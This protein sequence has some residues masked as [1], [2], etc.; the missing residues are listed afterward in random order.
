MNLALLPSI[1]I[2]LF[3][4]TSSENCEL[5][6][7]RPRFPEYEDIYEGDFDLIINPE[8]KDK[9]LIL[10]WQFLTKHNADFFIFRQR[11]EK[12]RIEIIDPSNDKKITLELWQALQ[13][14]KA[15]KFSSLIQWKNIRLFLE[16]H[17]NT[18]TGFRLR[19]DIEICYYF[20]HLQ[21]K[22]KLVSAPLVK[23]RFKYYSNIPN[24]PNR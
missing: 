8:H 7:L 14:R 19:P 18:L 22:K 17:P 16:Q 20:S 24:I 13:V 9:F 11:H 15:P 6:L 21:T 10:A 1:L 3:K 4:Y 12:I 5:A 2:N 23:M